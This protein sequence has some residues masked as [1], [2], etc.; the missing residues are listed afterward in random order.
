MAQLLSTGEQGHAS[1]GWGCW[2][3]RHRASRGTGNALYPLPVV[4][5]CGGLLSAQAGLEARE[6]RT[7]G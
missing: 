7:A 3:T 4:W 6:S 5:A 2:A 1:L